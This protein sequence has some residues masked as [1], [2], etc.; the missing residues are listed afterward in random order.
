MALVAAFTLDMVALVLDL[1]RL[2][3][4]RGGATLDDV[5]LDVA[6]QLSRA[7]NLAV[8]LA[9]A[10]AAPLFL[11]WFWCS[12]QR[13]ADTGLAS[14]AGWWGLVAWLV[15][16]LNLV[17]PARLMGELATRPVRGLPVRAGSGQV[18]VWWLGWLIGAV[19]QVGLRFVSPE[20]N[21]GWT[22]WQGSA[23][24]ANV[25]LVVGTGSV[26][27]LLSV[28]DDRLRAMAR[29]QAGP[30]SRARRMPVR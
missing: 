13:L 5:G 10:I 24:A 9:V 12:Y 8:P 18:T 11:W 17:R 15:P 27:A 28:V 25:L 30:T 20:T 23:L 7:A 3:R 26:M 21:I 14:F 2:R 19:V 4:L 1:E 22:W 29:I 16:G 6:S